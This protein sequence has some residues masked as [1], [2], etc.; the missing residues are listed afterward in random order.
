MRFVKFPAKSVLFIIYIK[1]APGFI[2]DR[3]GI[4]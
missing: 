2:E 4:W 1:D 3:Y